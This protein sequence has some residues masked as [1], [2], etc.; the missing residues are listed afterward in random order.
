MKEWTGGWVALSILSTT[1]V[2][3]SLLPCFVGLAPLSFVPLSPVLAPLCLPRL[4]VLH[5]TLLSMA[6]VLQGPTIDSVITRMGTQFMD[7]DDILSEG[8]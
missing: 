6:L 3:V 7:R 5:V 2:F 1:R 8:I 4:L